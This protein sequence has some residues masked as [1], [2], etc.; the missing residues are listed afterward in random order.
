MKTQKRYYKK[1]KLDLPEV[2]NISDFKKFVIGRDE[3]IINEI[4]KP[5]D[6]LIE[7]LYQDNVNLHKELS[8]QSKIIEKATKYEKEKDSLLDKVTKSD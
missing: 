1:T 2:P 4:I 6:E 5:K 7:K 8:K 3:K